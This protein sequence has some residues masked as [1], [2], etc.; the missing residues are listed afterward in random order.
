[1]TS[2]NQAFFLRAVR[3]TAGSGDLSDLRTFAAELFGY[4]RSHCEYVFGKS[5][6]LNNTLRLFFTQLFK[7]DSA[8]WGKETDTLITEKMTQMYTYP[9]VNI[10]RNLQDIFLALFLIENPDPSGDPD[11]K[12]YD[13]YHLLFDK[14]IHEM[15]AVL[16]SMF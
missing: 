6:K 8:F 7:P 14:H 11:W 15:F 4:F 16:S 9:L 13:K 2:V 12:Y 1:M 10:L 3:A 5:S